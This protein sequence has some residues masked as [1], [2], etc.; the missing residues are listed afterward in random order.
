MNLLTSFD[1]VVLTS[2]PEVCTA[3]VSIFILTESDLPRQEGPVK[4]GSLLGIDV[5]T[6]TVLAASRVF[7]G[8]SWQ[9][10]IMKKRRRKKSR[11]GMR[12]SQI[13]FVST[14][15]KNRSPSLAQ[16]L[17]PPLVFVL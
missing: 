5:I 10:K 1:D 11:Q 4:E 16:G 13:D 9:K 7:S 14:S 6:T 15:Q 3:T 2:S 8:G 17:D 12:Y